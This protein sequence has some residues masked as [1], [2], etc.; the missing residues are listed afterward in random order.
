MV[1]KSVVLDELTFVK[2]V[3]IKPRR[4]YTAALLIL[5]LIAF[6][7]KLCFNLADR[8]VYQLTRTCRGHLRFNHA[9]GR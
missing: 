6:S 7:V 9:A 1:E 5:L 8:A 2:Q 4:K 3:T